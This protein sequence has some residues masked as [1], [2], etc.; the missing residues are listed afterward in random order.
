M[1]LTGKL[2][3]NILGTSDQLSITLLLEPADH[4][5]REKEQLPCTAW[6]STKQRKWEY[7]LEVKLLETKDPAGSFEKNSTERV[8]LKRALSMLS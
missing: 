5:P 4:R 7:K 3:C 6:K 2:L 8:L 1:E